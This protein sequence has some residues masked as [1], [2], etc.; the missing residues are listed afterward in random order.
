M[1]AAPERAALIDV[2]LGREQADAVLENGRLLD[3][4]TGQVRPECAAIKNE[5][6]A[7]VGD[8]ASQS[9]NLGLPASPNG[10]SEEERHMT[11]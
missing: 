10:A 8:V 6:I 5:R 1:S 4:H 9:R 11:L 7:A 3:V 2:A